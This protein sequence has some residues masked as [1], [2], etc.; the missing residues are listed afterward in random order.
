MHFNNYYSRDKHALTI[1]VITI[2]KYQRRTV[3][4]MRCACACVQAC[5][6]MT[7]SSG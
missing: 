5:M 7:R 6:S 4:T 3:Q 2:H 1:E